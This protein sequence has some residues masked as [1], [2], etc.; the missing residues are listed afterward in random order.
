MGNFMHFLS[1]IPIRFIVSNYD[2][3][4]L[5]KHFD[6]LSFLV[7]N[8]KVSRFLQPSTKNNSRQI[9]YHVYAV[10]VS[11]IRKRTLQSDDAK[12]NKTFR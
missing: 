5:N 7:F 11:Y 6:A 10:L 3:V 8:L 2:L 1:F 4:D 9:F 12:I